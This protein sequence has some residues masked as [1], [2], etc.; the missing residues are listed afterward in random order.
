[1]R[2]EQ[3][4]GRRKRIADGDPVADYFPAVVDRETFL[5]ARRLRQGR[6][7]EG[8]R[9]GERFSNLFTGIA[10]CGHCGAP[11]HYVNK[12]NSTKGGSYLICSNARRG[13]ARCTNPAWRYLS[14]ER[15]VLVGLME[16]DYLELF[17]TVH[18]SAR[19]KLD[20]LT[21]ERLGKE[22]DLEKAKQQADNI[23]SL[24]A[25]RPDSPAFKDKL[26]VTGGDLGGP[27]GSH[28]R[29]WRSRSTQRTSGC[30]RSNRTTSR[31]R[32]PLRPSPRRCAA[33][34]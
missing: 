26:V 31:P 8:G 9:K 18:K 22:A 15:F 17:P 33:T 2:L 27:G 32:M 4:A 6:K 10:K 11:M 23:V 34:M 1:M 28:C 29:S 3:V 12:G 20:S 14:V 5:Q 13:A 21:R 24:L 7:I 19:E 25:D 16:V 30:E